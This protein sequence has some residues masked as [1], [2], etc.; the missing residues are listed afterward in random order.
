MKSIDE[1]SVKLG[2]K[3]FVEVIRSLMKRA[4]EFKKDLNELKK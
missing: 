3:P 4:K 2:N 1:T